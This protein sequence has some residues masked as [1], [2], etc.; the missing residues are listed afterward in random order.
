MELIVEVAKPIGAIVRKGKP[1]PTIFGAIV[2]GSLGLA[3]ASVSISFTVAAVLIGTIT[4]AALTAVLF[5]RSPSIAGVRTTDIEPFHVGAVLRSWSFEQ[6][7]FK[8]L[9]VLLERALYV[10]HDDSALWAMI[11]GKLEQGD[12]PDLFLGSLIRLDEIL[13]VEMRGP[14]VTEIQIVHAPEGKIKRRPIHFRTTAERDELL[15]S[16]ERH[17]RSSFCRENR[18]LEF[19]RILKGPLIVA[20]IVAAVFAG[21]AWLSAYWTHNPPPFPRGKAKPDALVSFLIGVGP[22]SVLLTGAVFLFLV[23]TWL[24]LRLLRPPLVIALQIRNG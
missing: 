23:L 3:A 9:A 14:D 2:G 13:C 21:I 4:G 18:S 17:F 11:L 12:V 22:G 20:V 15:A 10:V 1:L 6:G 16:L 19:T 24:G 8:S 5:R 7:D